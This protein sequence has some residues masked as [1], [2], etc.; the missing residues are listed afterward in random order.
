[1]AKKSSPTPEKIA[2]AASGPAAVRLMALFEGYAGAHGTHGEPR[3]KADNPLKWEIKSTAETLKR[4]VT[5]DLWA[6]HLAG[7]RPLGI[8]SIREDSMVRWGSIDYDVYDADL[9]RLIGEVQ[10]RK[11]PLVPGR[12]KS[13]GLHLF[14]F[15]RDWVPAALMQSSLRDVAAQLGIAGSEVFPKQTQIL[16]ERGDLGSWMVMPYYGGTYGGKLK[17]QVG[18]KKTGG[19][20]TLEE[21]VATC[22][23]AAVDAEALAKLARRAVPRP[24][25][26]GPDSAGPREAIP[27]VEYPEPDVPF[28]DGPPCLETLAAQTVPAGK[29]DNALFMMGI[30]YKRRYPEAWKE[31][32][33]RAA[34]D[35][36][37]P[38][39]RVDV[40]MGKIRSLEK[41]DYNYTCKTEPM[42]SFCSKEICRTRPFGVGNEDDYP[43]LRGMRVLKTDPPIWFV[44]VGGRTV[45]LNADML[46]NYA[47]FQRA[48]LS[49]DARIHLPMKQADWTVV[50]KHALE[51]CEPVPVPEDA[52]ERG[53]FEEVL[54]DFLANR[55]ESENVEGLLMG[56]PW[57]DTE[58]GRYVFR[59]KDLQ[60]FMVREGLK[61]LN[62]SAII[63]R[64]KFQYEAAA[65]FVNIKGHGVR[66]W[67]VRSEKVQ[68]VPDLDTPKQ[69]ESGI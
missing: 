60:V 56:R 35:Y 58:G 21:F 31:R 7:R 34:Q 24:R 4:P 57:L 3:Q 18:L 48:C 59:A 62:R 53:R 46:L 66:V 64:L 33:E 26:Q 37:L 6:Q 40:V 45:E 47:Q 65:D 68:R 32:I 44:E 10:R 67:A 43:D 28:G 39:G 42:C 2:G 11:L 36:L 63:Y 27:G 49:Q 13:G 41:R 51:N 1:M 20:M 15:T 16:V 22:E 14:C 17:E 54:Y 61:E 38:P 19:E 23:D 8:I 30:Y 29:Q 52:G 9:L 12:S 55:H 50:V 25:A 69:R 5:P